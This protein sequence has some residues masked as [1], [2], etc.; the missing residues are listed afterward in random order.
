MVSYL[1]HIASLQKVTTGNVQVKLVCG[2]IF[3]FSWIPD[4]NFVVTSCLHF[5][6]LLTKVA[7]LQ[8]HCSYIVFSHMYIAMPCIS[9]NT[10]K[11]IQL[12]IDCGLNVHVLDVRT[13]SLLY[14]ISALV[15][16]RICLSICKPTQIAI[17]SSLD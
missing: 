17:S 14:N 6:A 8:L 16:A 11:D 2:K 3:L 13:Q 9:H 15:D 7:I 4:E 10:S 5:V 1:R 12:H